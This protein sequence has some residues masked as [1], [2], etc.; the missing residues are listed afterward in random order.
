MVARSSG[1]LARRWA[2][3]V[4]FG[5]WLQEGGWVVLLSVTAG[6]PAGRGGFSVLKFRAIFLGLELS[7]PKLGGFK[8][9]LGTQPI[10]ASLSVPVTCPHESPAHSPA[11]LGMWPLPS[12]PWWARAVH[13]LEDASRPIRCV[14]VTSITLASYLVLFS[15]LSVM[16]WLL[17]PPQLAPTFIVCQAL[18][19]V[20][21]NSNVQ[22]PLHPRV[23]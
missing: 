9:N 1:W 19:P 14:V 20:L 10:A 6:H 2:P 17:A 15:L 4:L 12:F 5:P 22:V 16:V 13:L 18:F 23:Q 21:G 3:W 7:F 11:G 8:V